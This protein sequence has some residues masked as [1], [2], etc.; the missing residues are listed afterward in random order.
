MLD[1]K[2][3]IRYIN[4]QTHLKLL[5]YSAEELIGKSGILFIHPDEKDELSD[6]I[7]RLI[8]EG[9]ARRE[10][11]LLNKNGDWNWMDIWAKLVPVGD[12]KWNGIVVMRD[13]SES[14]EY[15]NKLK[16]SEERY[17]LISENA[18]DMIAVITE[19]LKLEYTNS[20]PLKR[21]LGYNIEEILGKNLVKFIH[22]E[23]IQLALDALRKGTKKGYNKIQLRFKHK[24]GTYRWLEI[25]G[26]AFKDPRGEY[27]GIIISRDITEQKKS[28]EKIKESEKTIRK[29]IESSYDGIV[30]TDENG[31]IIE[32]NE[33]L[34][35]ITGL[36]K[37]NALNKPIWEI[38]NS[39]LPKF[40]KND[41]LKSAIETEYRNALMGKHRA[42]LNRIRDVKLE[43]PN[44]ELRTIQ[45]L[46]FTMETVLGNR[47]GAICRDVTDIKKYQD[48]IAKSEKEYREAYDRANFYKDL[49]AHDI[50]NILQIINS[51]AEILQ[52][53]VEETHDYPKI[54]DLAKKIRKQV[55]R[56]AKLVNDVHTLSE[57]EKEHT[58]LV[59]VNI[60]PLLKES[61]KINK[62]TY[63]DKKINIKLNSDY[64]E[65][66][67]N[68]DNYLKQVFDNLLINSIKYNDNEQIDIQIRISDFQDKSNNFVKL[69]FTDNGIGI[70]DDHKEEIFKK[71]YRESK[72]TKGMGIG[73]ALVKKIL[74]LYNSKIWV[75]N[76]V[77]EDYTQGS[78]F[79]ILIPSSNPLKK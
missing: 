11:R 55:S 63:E 40:L 13:I 70:K 38:I 44:K 29:F 10:G 72:G 77:K 79:V 59:P 22:P 30:L 36:T 3:K 46:S 65:I 76:R 26:Q 5:G 64:M 73:L 7:K 19:D 78:N 58:K 32:W 35:I 6:F 66:V 42:W 74:N 43:R 52:I 33:A 61:I 28:M 60:Y 1:H 25:G 14:K 27:K 24:S 49:F 8:K 9:E 15:E 75:E 62:K 31:F 34:E 48:N 23:D 4:E 53:I 16:I 45:Q 17:R 18:N 68:A 12:K 56:G 51:S 2:L 39:T 69:E 57:L 54:P 67:V 21:I 20:K 50:N 37:E 71:G 47:L 41:S